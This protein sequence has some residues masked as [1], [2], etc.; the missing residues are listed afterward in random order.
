LRCCA[1]SEI[2]VAQVFSS[3]FTV[4]RNN[5]LVKVIKLVV[6]ADSTMSRFGLYTQNGAN[7]SNFRHV[8]DGFAIS[9]MVPIPQAAVQMHMQALVVICMQNVYNIPVYILV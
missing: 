5:Y 2:S 4:D 1:L 7:D 8:Q 6:I 3:I 9:L